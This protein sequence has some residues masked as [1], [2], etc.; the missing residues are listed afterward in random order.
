MS[1]L[2]LADTAGDTHTVPL[3]QS[4]THS[5]SRS[6]VAPCLGSRCC[7]FVPVRLSSKG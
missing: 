4:K 7:V 6:A 2:L 3:A 1:R 5:L